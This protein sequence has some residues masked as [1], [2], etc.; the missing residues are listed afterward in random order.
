MVVWEGHRLVL[1]RDDV[2]AVATQLEHFRLEWREGGTDGALAV[3]GKVFGKRTKPVGR[4][5]RGV[6]SADI[7]THQSETHTVR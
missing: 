7:P 1:H 5:G 4:I 2:V 3:L 6:R